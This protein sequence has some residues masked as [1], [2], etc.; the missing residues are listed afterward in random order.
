VGYRVLLQRRSPTGWVTK[1]RGTL[2]SGVADRETAATLTGSNVVRDPETA[3]VS[4]RYRAA[5]KLI[6]WDATA[7]I[8]GTVT[9]AVEHHLRD[10]DDSVGA[11]CKGRLPIG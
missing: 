6:W 7:R 4:G 1:A 5:L 8:Q 9:L 2:V 3:G 11:V 10:Y